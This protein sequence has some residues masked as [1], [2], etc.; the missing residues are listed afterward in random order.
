MENFQEIEK[1]MVEGVI[2]ELPVGWK[3]KLPADI[4]PEMVDLF[5]GNDNLWRW[6]LKPEFIKD[7][8]EREKYKIERE[9]WP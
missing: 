1:Q 9:K 4:K 2:G 5:L 8:K 6:H 3:E 7:E